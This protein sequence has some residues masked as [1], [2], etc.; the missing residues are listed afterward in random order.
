MPSTI[1]ETFRV[2]MHKYTLEKT[3]SGGL[4]KKKTEIFSQEM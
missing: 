1:K 4:K 3:S 2:H